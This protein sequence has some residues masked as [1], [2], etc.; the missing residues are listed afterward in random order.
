[1]DIRPYNVTSTPLQLEKKRLSPAKLFVPVILS[2]S[3]GTGGAMT[4]QGV[5][6]L[7]QWVYVPYVHVEKAMQEID[8]RTPA[9]HV[10]LIRDAFAL[11]MSELAAVLGIS[12]PTAYAWLAGQEP[13]ADAI[14]D[15]R[16]LAELAER[17]ETRNI[18]RI[19]KL[20]RRPVFGSESLIDKLKAREATPETL[21]LL[22]ELANKEAQSRR[23]TKGSGKVRRSLSE[24]SEDYSSSAYNRG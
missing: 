4:T 15:I 7:N 2:F 24:T 22:E 16:R 12:R 14:Q 1:M 8:T 23:R 3:A 20:V 18:P 19:D 5:E 11:N 21:T 6:H 9:E 13:K 10:V 17:L